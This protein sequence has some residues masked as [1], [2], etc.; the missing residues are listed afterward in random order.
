VL[1]GEA[2]YCRSGVAQLSQAVGAGSRRREVPFGGNLGAGD[3]GFELVQV[4]PRLFQGFQAVCGA[5][6]GP[7]EG[8]AQFPPATQLG[9][10]FSSFSVVV[11]AE[12]ASFS[13]SS[14]SRLARRRIA[15][16]CLL[17]VSEISACSPLSKPL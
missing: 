2:L 10:D 11:S 1:G 7:D 8:L 14:V 12:A 5:V 15:A 16:A 4:D 13:A 6:F 3:A 9:G 17:R